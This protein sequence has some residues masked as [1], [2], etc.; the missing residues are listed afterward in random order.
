MPPQAKHGLESNS[1]SFSEITEATVVAAAAAKS[2][3]HEARDENNNR[4]TRIG[5]LDV[6]PEPKNAAKRKEIVPYD[7]SSDDATAKTEARAKSPKKRTK[8]EEK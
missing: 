4:I 7:D 2:A 5:P 8:N 6:A 1:Q 3:D